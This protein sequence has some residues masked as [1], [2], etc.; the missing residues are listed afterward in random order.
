LYYIR[1]V[2]LDHARVGFPP[3]L[4]VSL[5]GAT[6]LRCA[7]PDDDM[8][9]HHGGGSGGGGDNDDNDDDDDD[10]VARSA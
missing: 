6:F 4:V 2:T 8:S 5:L 3:L 1:T 9:S 10:D 7:I